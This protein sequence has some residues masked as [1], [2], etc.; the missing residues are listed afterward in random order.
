M[1]RRQTPPEWQALLDSA[2]ISSLNRLASIADL[3]QTTATRVVHG[4]HQPNAET[5]AALASALRVPDSTIYKLTHGKKIAT[6]EWAPPAEV[7]RL[8]RREQDA[9][10][11]MI[12]AMAASREREDV[13]G[14]DNPAP[15]TQ[16]EDTSAAP[17]DYDLAAFEPD[18]REHGITP[19]AVGDDSA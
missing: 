14:N 12:R 11:E 10:T 8:S 19:D 5:V 13:T 18:Q 2:G 7:Q 6:R 17:D 1:A 9:L 16:A 4:D 15:I 3:S